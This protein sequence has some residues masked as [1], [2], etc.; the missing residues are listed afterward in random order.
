MYPVLNIES[1]ILH[2]TTLFRFIEAA[3]RSGLASESQPSSEGIKD[4]N[5]NILKM[6]LANALT[7]E[8]SGQSEIGNRLFESV[9]VHADALL[10]SE[11]VEIKGLSLFVLVVSWNPVLH[12]EKMTVRFWRKPLDSNLNIWGCIGSVISL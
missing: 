7:V 11:T 8:G 5:S 1:V 9:K 10:H 12:S 2:A 6:V 3:F 4:E